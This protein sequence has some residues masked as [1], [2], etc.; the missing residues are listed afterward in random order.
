MTLLNHENICLV[1]EFINTSHHIYQSWHFINHHTTAMGL[2]KTDCNHVTLLTMVTYICVG[3]LQNKIW[4][5]PDRSTILAKYIY[6]KEGKLARPNQIL[7]VRVRRRELI[8]EDWSVI[9][10]ID[11][12]QFNDNTALITSHRKYTMEALTKC[13]MSQVNKSRKCGCFVIYPDSKVH[14]ANTGPTWV[15]MAPDGP[16]FGPMNFAIRVG[17]TQLIAKPVNKSAPPLWRDPF[18]WDLYNHYW[19]TS[20]WAQCLHVLS[21]NVYLLSWHKTCVMY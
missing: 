1:T 7:P 16:H 4:N 15:L 8:F 12:L 6:D 2:M 13:V 11:I 9:R 5:L 17:F 18:Q 19:V 20:W 3:S 14:G 21:N 10:N